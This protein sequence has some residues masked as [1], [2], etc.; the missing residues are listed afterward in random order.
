MFSVLV[1]VLNDV[2]GFGSLIFT[3][4]GPFEQ[5]SLLI[6]DPCRMT[7]RELSTK[8]KRTVEI[9]RNVPDTAQRNESKVH[10]SVLA[11]SILREKKCVRGCGGC[12]VRGWCARF[13]NECLKKSREQKQV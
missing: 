5:S 10:E 13:S 11:A 4:A 7:A 9:I 3:D 12:S 6:V 2:E 1:R 8:M